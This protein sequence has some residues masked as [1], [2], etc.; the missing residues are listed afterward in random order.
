VARGHH[1][2]SVLVRPR[3]RLSVSV[4]SE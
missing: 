2:Q 3:V 4:K 1:R